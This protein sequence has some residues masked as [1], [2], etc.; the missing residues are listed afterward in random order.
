[1]IF[2]QDMKGLIELFEKY[3]IKYVLVGGFAVNFYGYVR[4][5]QDIDILI[6]PSP[7]NAKKMMKALGEFGFGNAGIPKECFENEGTAIHLGVEPNR[8]DLLTHLKGVSNKEI[9]AKK[10]RVL[11]E[12]V[13]LHIISFKDLLDCKKCSHRAKDLADVEELEKI[14]GAKDLRQLSDK[15]Q[16]LS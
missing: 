8:I 2:T 4:T 12:K 3:N 14:D 13:S 1:M 9:F 7:K 16:I 15:Q 5:T 10:K 11:Y 6:Y